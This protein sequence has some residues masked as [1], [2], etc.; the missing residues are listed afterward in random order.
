MDICYIM[1]SQGIKI[2]WMLWCSIIYCDPRLPL[3]QNKFT[4]S[5]FQLPHARLRTTLPTFLLHFG[6]S[7][8][9]GRGRFPSDS[10]RL[11]WWGRWS[12]PDTGDSLQ[13][14]EPTCGVSSPGTHTQT[15][16]MLLYCSEML[17]IPL[18]H[19]SFEGIHHCSSD[20]TF[21]LSDENNTNFILPALASES[22][23]Y[24]GIFSQ[25]LCFITTCK[26]QTKVVL[27]C[28]WSFMLVSCGSK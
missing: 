20:W 2:V 23:Y 12:A 27:C 19:L 10:V 1:N 9:S 15:Q 26:T 28:Y 22:L 13:S 25:K 8:G 14:A 7:G 17:Y 21:Y 16:Y 6:Q 11:V 18:L 5:L 24:A 3:T 4:S